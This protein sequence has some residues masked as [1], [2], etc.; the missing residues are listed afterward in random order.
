MH[1]AVDWGV[2]HF[3]FR[4]LKRANMKLIVLYWL[5][6]GMKMCACKSMYITIV[7]YVL[8]PGLGSLGRK[9]KEVRTE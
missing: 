6:S 5:S 2:K 7:M 1:P 9:G 3:R 8:W 4:R